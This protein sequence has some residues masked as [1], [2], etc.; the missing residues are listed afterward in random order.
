MTDTAS[1]PSG[2][3]DLKLYLPY[4]EIEPFLLHGLLAEALF[5][6]QLRQDGI[7]YENLY[8]AEREQRRSAASRQAYVDLVA[9][10]T[11]P[12]A[13]LNRFVSDLPEPSPISSR[14]RP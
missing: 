2:L 9:N 13:V 3:I 8:R 14:G 5:R 4:Q 6:K 7:V 12:S 10:G 11:F 1:A